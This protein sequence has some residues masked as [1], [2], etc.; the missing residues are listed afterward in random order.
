MPTF[1]TAQGFV[2]VPVMSWKFPS[3][4]KGAPDAAPFLA[5]RENRA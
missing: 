2:Q 3:G 1:M 5:E 4:R